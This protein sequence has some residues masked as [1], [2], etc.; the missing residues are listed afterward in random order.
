M[1]GDNET[2]NVIM[3]TPRMIEIMTSIIIIVN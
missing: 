2:I 1:G 3:I